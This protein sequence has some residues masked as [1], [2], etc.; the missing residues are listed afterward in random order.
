MRYSASLAD[1]FANESLNSFNSP[2]GTNAVG[3][4]AVGTNAVG[5]SSDCYLSLL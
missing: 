5:V 3:T 4:N 2:E 1:G